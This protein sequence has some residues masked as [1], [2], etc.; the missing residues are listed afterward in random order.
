MHFQ[1]AA[2]RHLRGSGADLRWASCYNFFGD[3]NLEG[4]GVLSPLLLILARADQNAL[5]LCITE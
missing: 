1:F 3:N 5:T 4:G 2:K